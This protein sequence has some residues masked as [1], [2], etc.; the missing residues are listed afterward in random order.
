MRGDNYGC[1]DNSGN[2][3]VDPGVVLRVLSGAT[4][5]TNTPTCSELALT[6]IAAAA[7]LLSVILWF[8]YGG[9]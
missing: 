3:V 2:F 9:I 4:M 5:N 8:A 1:V 7:C 6:T